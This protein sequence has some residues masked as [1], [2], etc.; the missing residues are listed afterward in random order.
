MFRQRRILICNPQIDH[1]R[2]ADA[3]PSFPQ[4]E[5]LDSTDSDQ[6]Q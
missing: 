4:L 3:P 6:P 5:P 1:N 2:P